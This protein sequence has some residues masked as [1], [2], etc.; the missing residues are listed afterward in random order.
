[1]TIIYF[2]LILGIIVFVHEFGHFIFAKKAGIYVYE[3]SIGMGP[4]IFKWHR[5][6]D[7][8]VYAIRLFPIGGFV[9]MAGEEVEVDEKIPKEKRMQS[10]TWLQRFMTV[11]AGIM[12]NFILALVL[13][14]VIGFVSGSQTNKSYVGDVEVG[15]KAYEAGLTS[16]SVI[17][18]IDGKKVNN[19]D[20]LMLEFQVRVGQ[21]ID[22]EVTT[23]DGETKNISITPEK[24]DSDKTTSYKYGFSLK[25]TTEHGFIAAIKYAFR[26]TFSLI[27][28]MFFIIC[29]LFTG[30]LS[31]KSLSGPIGIFTV[32]GQTAKTGFINLVYLLALIS[33]NVG[34]INFLPL[35]AFDGGRILFL[36]IEKI[37]GSP[38]N[39]KIENIIHSIGF[40]LLML[41]MVVIS[42]NDII[43]LLKR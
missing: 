34:F 19:Y 23:A 43:N 11:I 36:I 6:N 13:L 35:P 33:I 29:Y 42:Y 10:K 18:K 12:F 22:F 16:G 8:T 14:F 4:Q 7:E 31:L 17:N 28:Q 40:V 1:M 26:K 27:E 30:K 3:F 9:Q 32:V 25:T 38:V 37:K 21:T 24:I 5:K 41:L 15:S 2:I 20:R 39:T